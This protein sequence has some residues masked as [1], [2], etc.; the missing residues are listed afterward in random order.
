MSTTRVPKISA[1]LRAAVE[2]LLLAQAHE[3][4]VRPIVKDIERAVL[5]A[6]PVRV[7]G[8]FSDRRRLRIDKFVN[9]DGCIIDPE[10]LYLGDN[11][12]C[13]RFYVA[14]RIAIAEAGLTPDDPTH[15]PLLVAEVDVADAKRLVIEAGAYLTAKTGVQVT[16]AKLSLL[17]VAKYNQFVD[18]TVR[19]VLSECPDINTAS[20][21]AKAVPA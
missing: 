18:L 6:N 8:E 4:L 13:D 10:Y 17:G 5:A 20:V 19:F 12:D 1:E 11:D 9:E 3:R 7:S 21:M 15:C 16:P 2:A 14:K